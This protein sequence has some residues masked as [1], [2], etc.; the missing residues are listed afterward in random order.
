MPGVEW[1]LGRPLTYG[2][3]RLELYSIVLCRAASCPQETALVPD[4]ET[5]KRPMAFVRC[6]VP[7]PCC[8]A[9]RPSPSPTAQQCNAQ[10]RIPARYAAVAV[11]VQHGGML[12]AELL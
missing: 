11:V 2:A 7:V 5:R 10:C 9:Q 6:T 12:Y 8:A 4:P 1:D 3:D